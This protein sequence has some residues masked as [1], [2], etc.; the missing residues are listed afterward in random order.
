M[1]EGAGLGGLVGAVVGGV[2][3]GR[4]AACGTAALAA[5]SG[6]YGPQQQAYP[7]Y[8]GGGGYGGGYAQQGGHPTYAN[9][10]PQPVTYY[11]YRRTYRTYTT[12]GP[13][14]PQPG[15]YYQD[16]YA[17][18]GYDQGPPPG[19]QPCSKIWKYLWMV[20]CHLGSL[21]LCPSLVK[22]SRYFI[23]RL[24]HL[25]I[26]SIILSTHSFTTRSITLHFLSEMAYFLVF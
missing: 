8:G 4:S 19:Y 11:E 24:T 25:V 16:G 20:F 22:G 9:A 14:G 21:W 2:A 5:A 18:Q 23:H 26:T 15:P 7:V 13:E 1:A 12:A 3:G 6:A 10:G 17:Q